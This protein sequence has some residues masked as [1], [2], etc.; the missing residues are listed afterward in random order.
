MDF[1]KRRLID[2]GLKR[3]LEKETFVSGFFV[4]AIEDEDSL[5]EL[6]QQEGDANSDS[7]LHLSDF[8]NSTAEC[9]LILCSILKP[10]MARLEFSVFRFRANKMRKS[11]GSLFERKRLPN[12]SQVYFS[13]LLSPLFA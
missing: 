12:L 1:F 2:A 9:T 8:Q 6:S 10:L 13:T 3:L 4:A 7:P 5:R 11:Q